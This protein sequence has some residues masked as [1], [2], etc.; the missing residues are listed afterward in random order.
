MF[1]ILTRPCVLKTVSRF[2]QN[3]LFSTT[4]TNY[5]ARV[6]D[7]FKGA[8][9]GHHLNDYDLFATAKKPN[10]N[11]EMISPGAIVFSN[12]KV[13]RSPNKHKDPIGALL[14]N[15]Q[16]FEINFKNCKLERN[17]I[18][19]DIDN[20]LLDLLRVIYPKPELMVLGSGKQTRM[21]SKATREGFNKLGIRL[22]INDTQHA[23][24]NYDMLA[25]ERTPALV[26]ALLLP[27]NW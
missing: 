21:I 13:I 19:L 5:G 14:L 24:M 3:K 7:Q 1:P 8:D 23:A 6:G 26:G 10:S 16:I 18:V 22:D 27:S 4:T 17:K 11:I 12:M 2:A 15:D 20:K 25:T 9:L